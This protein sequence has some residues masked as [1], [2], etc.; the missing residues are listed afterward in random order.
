MFF[1]S[2][3]PNKIKRIKSAVVAI[4]LKRPNSRFTI[5]GSGFCISN[6]GEIVT[7]AHLF[8][9]FNDQQITEI[10][11]FVL[12]KQ[13]GAD[14]EQYI[15]IDAS[16]ITREVQNDIAILQLSDEYKT[17]LLTP[18]NIGDSQKVQVGQD[19]YYIGFPYAA[20]LINDGFGVTLIA[21]KGMVSNIKSGQDRNRNG[22][23][24]DCISNPGNSGC[25]LIDSKTN[26]VIG[27]MSL[28]FSKKSQKYQDLDIREP[29]HIALARPIN[30]AK[31]LIN[32]SK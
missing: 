19:V 16:I 30:L 7:A 25:P 2:K 17:S 32:T 31:K 26:Q 4:G 28:S 6:N 1:T 24:I 3:L 12:K 18:I 13:E 9:N 5:L 10:S 29:M 14:F 22:L 11:A 20:Q 15:W 21:N 27:I 23:I 8:N